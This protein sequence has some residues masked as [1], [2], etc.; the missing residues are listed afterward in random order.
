MINKLVERSENEKANEFIGE[1]TAEIAALVDETYST[2]I[3]CRGKRYHVIKENVSSL[4]RRKLVFYVFRDEIEDIDGNDIGIWVRDERLT[5]T[6]EELILKYQDSLKIY[7]DNT[8]E[9][10]KKYS[11]LSRISKP[12]PS[13]ELH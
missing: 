7:Q 2:S 11:L 8:C 5:N 3:R 6:V 9:D 12:N 13:S 10:S 4:I 1:L